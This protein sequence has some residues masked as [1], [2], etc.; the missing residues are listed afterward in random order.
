M[1]LISSEAIFLIIAILK[2]VHSFD[3][4]KLP[5]DC[6]FAESNDQWDQKTE[7]FICNSL[8]K[9]F[10]FDDAK[11]KECKKNA[12][13][14]TEVFFKLDKSEILG[15]KLNLASM[16]RFLR[17]MNK[18]HDVNSN[19][20]TGITIT[21]MNLKGFDLVNT[22]LAQYVLESAEN[23]SDIVG[24]SYAIK[25]YESRMDFYVNNTESN[26]CEDFLR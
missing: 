22:P 11:L 13:I 12:L 10:D 19:N 25:V 8:D 17:K 23:N 7:K 21:Y 20:E 3:C 18:Q 26:S 16:D 5:N 24:Y 6:R 9:T 2:E 1:N 4:D 14:P 15:G